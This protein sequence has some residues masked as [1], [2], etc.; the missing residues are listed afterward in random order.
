[1]SQ[2]GK[3]ISTTT[4]DAAGKFQFK[5]EHAGRYSVR[6]EAKTFATSTSEEVFAEP[7]HDVDR[8][9]HPVAV[10]GSAEHRGDGHRIG[11]S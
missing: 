1:M 10:R 11:D 5:I 7:G 3:D 8:Q 4:T 6:A 9:P 2:S